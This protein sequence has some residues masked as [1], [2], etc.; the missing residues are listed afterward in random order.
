MKDSGANDFWIGA[1]GNQKKKKK[2]KKKNTQKTTTT[3]T[4]IKAL[5]ARVGRLPLSV[6][7]ENGPEL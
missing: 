5:T 2:K 4:K 6:N 1:S 3:N 7:W